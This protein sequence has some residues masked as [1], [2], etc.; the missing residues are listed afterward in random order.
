MKTRW[1]PSLHRFGQK[2]DH[3]FLSATWRW[4]T[5]QTKRFKTAD[6]RAMDDQSWQS[7][8]QDLRIRIQ[9]AKETRVFQRGH[10][11]HRRNCAFL[12]AATKEE[13][14]KQENKQLTSELQE[15]TKCVQETIRAVV[16]SKK[17][18][19]K[20]GREM[21]K[22]TVELHEKRRKAYSKKKPTKAERKKWN[23]KISRSCRNDYR[24]W[25]SKWT[26]EIEKE[27]RRGN[28]KA[29]YA[30]VRQ[31]CGTKKSFATKQPTKNSNGGKIH[32]PE[33]LAK[34]WEKFS[35]KK[36]QRDRIGK[37]RERVQPTVRKRWGR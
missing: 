10:N 22:E 25:V 31:L 21:S 2:F 5:K 3:G 35:Q 4:K 36:V 37:Y 23:R 17:K 32:S 29:I 13:F 26:E 1:G 34:E 28:A 30:G 19:K 8:D 14:A 27:F 33:E 11:G 9:E 24:K 7:F 6:Y 12:N 16:P 18:Q 15:F 20:H